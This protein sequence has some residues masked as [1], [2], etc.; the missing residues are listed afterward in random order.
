MKAIETRYKG[1]RFRSRLEARW[2]VFFDKVGLEWV[3]EPE[4]FDLGDAGWYLPD[5]RIPEWRDTY[6]EVKP[7]LPTPEE[8]YKFLKLAQGMAGSEQRGFE[9]QVML[10][11]TPGVP[12]LQVKDGKVHIGGGYMAL[13][14][15]GKHGDEHGPFIDISCFAMT[16]G[17]TNLDIWPMY[18]RRLSGATISP[19]N[20]HG[21]EEHLFGLTLFHG[22]IPRIYVGSGVQYDAPLLKHAYEA[23]RSARFEHG[24]TPR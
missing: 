6:I 5:F 22:P 3:Y 20:L 19:V 15:T 13:T 18:F 17:G 10:C 16:S 12:H 14:A 2:A 1:Y 9:S 4:G 21:S 23:A 24:E 7:T 11:G 8:L